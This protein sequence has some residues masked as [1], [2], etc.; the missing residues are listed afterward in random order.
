MLNILKSEIL[1][2]KKDAMFYTGTIISILIPVLIIIKDK[3]LSTTPSEIM[4]WVM[5]CCLIYSNFAHKF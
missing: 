1:K 2:L 4:D 5:S 3:F